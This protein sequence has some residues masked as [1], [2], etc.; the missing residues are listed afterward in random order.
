MVPVTNNNF[1]DLKENDLY[2]TAML[3]LFAFSDNPKYSTLCELSYIL[4]HDSF[5]KFI[6]YYAGQTITVPSL[7]DVTKALRT[8]MLYQYYVVEGIDW[9]DAISKAG[10]NPDESFTARRL[11]MSFRKSADQYKIGDVLNSAA[12]KD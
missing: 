9:K 7:P 4:D 10:F 12:I 5:M 11:L 8:L 3:L 6:K 1:P 2:S